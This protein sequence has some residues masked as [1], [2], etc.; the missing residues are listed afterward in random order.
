[1]VQGLVETIDRYLGANGRAYIA[2]RNT[3]QGVSDFWQNVMPEAGFVLVDKISCRKYQNNSN[4]AHHEDGTEGG[5]PPG[6]RNE[7]HSHR[8]RG[9]HTIY[10]FERIPQKRRDD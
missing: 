3:R 2:L 8:W 4:N 5:L 10:V 6:F 9:D 1:M 7:A